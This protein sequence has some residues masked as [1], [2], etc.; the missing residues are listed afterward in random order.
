MYDLSQ[1]RKG[2]RDHGANMFEIWQE[3]C[4]ILT[5]WQDIELI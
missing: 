3:D 2:H 5:V 1:R 4:Y